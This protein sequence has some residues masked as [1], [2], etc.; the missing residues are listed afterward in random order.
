MN[1][2]N[3]LQDN[4]VIEDDE[5]ESDGVTETNGAKQPEETEESPKKTKGCLLAMK[6]LLEVLLNPIDGWKRLRRANYTPE[7]FA[8]DCFYPLIALASASCLMTCIYEA[9]I[10]LSDA[11]ME[12]LKFFVAFFFSHF[13]I[14][15]FGNWVLPSETRISM[16]SA[17]GKIFVM[18]NLSTLALFSILYSTLPM[19]T[20]VLLFLPLWTIYLTAR[21]MRF[22]NL[23]PEK[24]N[25]TKTLVCVLILG[26][27]SLCYLGLDFLLEGVGV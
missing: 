16:D 27:P 13:L 23:P 1:Q 22:F 21:G 12:A 24:A 2:D 26:V 4:Y 7:E 8:R 18:A 14:I 19:L 15:I 20:P 6:L 9:A 11:M 25:M 5:P 3:N 10:T 17:F